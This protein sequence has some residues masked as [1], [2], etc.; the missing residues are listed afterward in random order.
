[1]RFASA[2]SRDTELSPAVARAVAVLHAELGGE[3]PHLLV[4]FASRHF[5]L[6]ASQL[7]TLLAEAFPGVAQIGCC[8]GGVIG[9]G[10]ELEDAPALSITA[11]V[12]PGVGV[13][14]FHLRTGEVPQ[15]P[16]DTAAMLLFADPFT[17][18]MNALVEAL[19]AQHPAVPKVGGM[20]SGGAAPGEHFLFS[21]DFAWRSGA[22]GVALSGP[23]RVETLVAQG[24]RPVGAPMFATRVEGHLV[25]EL[26]GK[27][28]MQVLETLYEG[29]SER[30]QQLMR[31]SLFIGLE[32]R[33]DTVEHR[34]DELLVRNLLG[35]EPRR[36]ALAVGAELSP[37]QVL[38]FVLRDKQ[39]ATD[40]LKRVLEAAQARQSGPV[41]GALLFSCT[42]RGHLLFGEADHDSRAFLE[43]FGPTPLGGFFCSG[44]V[45]PVGGRT[46]LH[47]YT[48]AFALFRPVLH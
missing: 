14:T 5:T 2:L 40:D 48:S 46:Y 18:D 13:R 1:M 33:K 4:V 36:K 32:M 17:Y 43:A 8:G 3:Q 16:Q 47:A 29:M 34:P 10:L 19:D 7:A 23:V 26:D 30:D 35:V 27:A 45:G 38:Q 20:A 21:N 6:G 41:A 39:A 31:R 12:L 24:C 44:E 28:P 9:A 37:Y 15:L 22:V 11:A 25:L 42:G